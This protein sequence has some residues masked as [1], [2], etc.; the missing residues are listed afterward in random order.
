[1]NVNRFYPL[2]SLSLSLLSRN[3]MFPSVDNLVGLPTLLQ[4]R[5]DLVNLAPNF[6]GAD[7]AAF[8]HGGAL[9][10]PGR[11]DVTDS[12]GSGGS[13]VNLSTANSQAGP[14]LGGDTPLWSPF[15]LDEPT[16]PAAD[17]TALHSVG[18]FQRLLAFM[19]R[20]AS[21]LD[22]LQKR[23]G[24]HPPFGRPYPVTSPGVMSLNAPRTPECPSGSV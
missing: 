21:I 8:F 9:Q 10:D 14:L 12:D 23:S 24:Q 17:P 3:M 4:Q 2:P 7:A 22:S 6:V 15:T 16:Y 19:S 18:V 11:Q 5:S 20:R 13:P 1:M